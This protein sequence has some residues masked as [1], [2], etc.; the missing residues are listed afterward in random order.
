MF[1]RRHFIALLTAMMLSLGAIAFADVPVCPNPNCPHPD[2]CPGAASGVCPFAG[3]GPGP[4]GPGPGGCP[5]PEDCPNPDCPN[6]GQ[7]PQRRG[8]NRP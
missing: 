8:P 6:E 2:E 1:H 4:H 5:N 7:G 3:Q